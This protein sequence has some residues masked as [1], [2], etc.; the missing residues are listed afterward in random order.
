M[1]VASRKN[2]ISIPKYNRSRTSMTP[3]A[4]DSKWLRNDSD[5]IASTSHCGVQL[6]NT[7]STSGNPASRN[8]KHTTTARMK[9]I[10][11]LRVSADMHE[12]MARNPPA[13]NRLPM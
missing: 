8:R 4:M 3:L 2:A 1:D 6:R 10:T 12:P 9:A 7:S 5:A 11:W 13:S